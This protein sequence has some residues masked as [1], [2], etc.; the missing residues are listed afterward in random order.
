MVAWQLSVEKS[1]SLW[2]KESTVSK[3]K[4]LQQ[5]FVFDDFSYVCVCVCV[6]C[7]S[8]QLMDWQ[9]TAD[10][11]LEVR[12]DNRAERRRKWEVWEREREG[13]GG[14]RW[15]MSWGRWW[16]KV[17][18]HFET[19][20]EGEFPQIQR[21]K[22]A[23]FVLWISTISSGF[24][25]VN[26]LLITCMLKWCVHYDFV[27]TWLSPVCDFFQKKGG[28]SECILIHTPS[29]TPPLFWKHPRSMTETQGH[30][31]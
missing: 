14:R 16:G 20:W 28:V 25:W 26:C 1:L 18:G 23:V 30:V 2:G 5:K 6:V 13:G 15:V 10:S 7:V 12:L 27:M 9:H 31:I 8:L 22:S 17:V 4:M 29:D 3:D 19:R 24:L 11:P 21:A